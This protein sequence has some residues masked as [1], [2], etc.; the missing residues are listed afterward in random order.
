MDGRRL[1]DHYCVRGRLWGGVAGDREGSRLHKRHGQ[2]HRWRT[3]EQDASTSMSRGLRVTANSIVVRR[4]S[5]A[6]PQQ[7]G[8]RL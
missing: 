5:K 8:N 2:A 4:P 6:T 7:S 1:G 3:S